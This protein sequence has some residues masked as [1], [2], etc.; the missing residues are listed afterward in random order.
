MFKVYVV[1]SVSGDIGMIADILPAD[2]NPGKSAQF[3]YFMLDSLP[4]ETVPDPNRPKAGV[5]IDMTKLP[6]F[7]SSITFDQLKSAL[8]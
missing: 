4:E 8:V 2:K 6:S 7:G 1:V 5:R 3:D